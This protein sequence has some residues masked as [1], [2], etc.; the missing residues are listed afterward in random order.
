MSESQKLLSE[1]KVGLKQLLLSSGHK[2][3]SEG[4][5]QSPFPPYK[6]V[7]A[8]IRDFYHAAYSQALLH[9]GL[10]NV[11]LRLLH[12]VVCGEVAQ[13]L[14]TLICSANREVG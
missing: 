12:A 13:W 3:I 7:G 1:A 6:S 9:G 10:S 14:A 11:H 8:K 4:S 2:K 5:P